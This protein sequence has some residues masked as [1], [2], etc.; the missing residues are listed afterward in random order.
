MSASPAL[1]D[2]DAVWE[3]KRSALTLVHA[4]PRSRGAARPT[5]AAF[6]RARGRR[7]GRLRDLVRAGRGARRRLDRVARA[8]AGPAARPAVAAARDELADR[9][10]FFCWLQWVVDEQLDAAQA[11][12]HGVRDGARHRAR[13]GRRRAPGR[14]RHLGA[15]GRDGP[16]GHRRRAAG[17]VQPGRSGL[18]AAAVAAGPAGR[19]RLRCRTATCCAR[20]CGTRAASGS[21]TSSGCS[22]CGGCPRAGP[23]PRAPTSAS[24]TRRWSG[25]WRWRPGGPGPLVVGEDLGTVEPWVR[26]YLA[27]ARRARHVDPVVRARLTQADAALPPE[28][29]AASCAWRRSRPTTCRRRPATSPASTSGSGPSL[30]LLT[31]PVEEERA[32]RRGRPRVLARPAGRARLARRGRRARRTGRDRRPAPG[33]RRDAEPAARGRAHRRGRRRAG[34]EPARHARTSTRTGRLPLAD[35]DGPP[36][37]LD[38]LV[39]SPRAAELAAAVR[40]RA[41]A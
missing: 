35:G 9:V 30:G 28:T 17:R 19:G 11:P 16:R 24:T 12:G 23:P 8:A 40:G 10:D 18:V 2:R 3:A 33:P 14:R 4:V 38:D 27:D 22:G 36:V 32:C 37:L 29:L 15:A 34:D 31:R 26:D 13:P 7:A 21:T 25:S 5:T 1:I 20:C 41:S 6:L 39:G